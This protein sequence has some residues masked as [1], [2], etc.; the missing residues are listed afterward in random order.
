MILTSARRVA[1]LPRRWYSPLCT[2][3]RSFTCPASDSASISSRKSVPRSAA[4][5]RPT[6]RPLAPV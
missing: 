2:T 4:S 3:R 1:L 5:K 6:R